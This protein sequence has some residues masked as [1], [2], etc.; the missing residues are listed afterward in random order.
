MKA[1]G[2]NS[3]KNWAHGDGVP[4]RDIV[5]HSNVLLN[6]DLRKTLVDGIREAIAPLAGYVGSVT[7]EV[8]RAR[9]VQKRGRVLC[10]IAVDGWHSGPLMQVEHR[11][12]DAD[13]AARRALRRF[14]P[15]L[16]RAH[17]EKIGSEEQPADAAS[18][19]ESESLIGRRV[20]RAQRNINAALERPKGGRRANVQ[21]TARRNA[22]ADTSKMTYTLEDSVSDRPSR[23]STRRGKNRI[24]AGTPLTSTTQRNV[25]SPESR[26][27]RRGA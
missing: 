5:I 27:A 13:E 19:D 20:G 8:T 17:R 25:H 7:V 2:R 1:P 4:P 26:H 6:A 9:G 24:K 14:S 21:H 11:A 15:E 10:R 18:L 23:K 12:D 22:K 16:H 3:S